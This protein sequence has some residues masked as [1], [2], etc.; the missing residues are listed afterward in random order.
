MMKCVRLLLKWM[1]KIRKFKKD[2]FAEDEMKKDNI[3]EFLDALNAVKEEKRTGFL[4][5]RIRDV[6][7]TKVKFSL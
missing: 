5:L 7:P 4:N 1:W 6:L 3:K 2:N